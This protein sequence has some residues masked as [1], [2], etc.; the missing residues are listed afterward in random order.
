MLS[1][2]VHFCTSEQILVVYF[3]LDLDKPLIIFWCLISFL[4]FFFFN[5]NSLSDN[6]KLRSAIHRAQ[7]FKSETAANR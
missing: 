1:L 4:G 3:S 6:F 5:S 2:V 7:S